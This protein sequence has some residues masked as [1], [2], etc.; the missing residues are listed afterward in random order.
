MVSFLSTIIRLYDFKIINLNE[1]TRFTD[2]SGWPRPRISWKKA[3]NQFQSL[4]YL[5][6]QSVL[7]SNLVLNSANEESA[8]NSKE[9][10]TGE[11]VKLDSGNLEFRDI[12][13]G[14]RH[15]VYGNG[16]LIIQEV[17]K[18]DESYFMCQ[19]SNG[20]G[21]GLSRVMF[22]KVNGKLWPAFDGAT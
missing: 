19:I 10:F 5:N 6:A 11:K 18:S 8:V 13:S 4:N 9:S 2:A 17:D 3:F 12:L 20:V 22:L 16:S 7:K 1:I 14:Y 21:A 15:Q